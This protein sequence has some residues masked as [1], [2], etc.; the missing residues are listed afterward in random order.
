LCC[1]AAARRTSSDI[2][3][4]SALCLF[5][6]PTTH[7]LFL[8]SAYYILKPMPALGGAI[9][10]SNT[11]GRDNC[12][13]NAGDRWTAHNQPRSLVPQVICYDQGTLYAP[14]KRAH[15]P[16]AAAFIAPVPACRK[17]TNSSA[18]ANLGV[19]GMA[20]LDCPL[21]FGNVGMPTLH[22]PRG[23]RPCGVIA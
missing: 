16:G 14:K 8:A 13:S 3:I 17:R 23:H 20:R 18:A 19:L 11:G 22:N 5:T 9:S 6:P 15:Y 7:H 21:S 1:G 10:D 4:L 2:R 12:A